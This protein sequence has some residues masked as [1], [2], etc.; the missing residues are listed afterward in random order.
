MRIAK[1]SVFS[2]LN[3]FEI[4]TIVENSFSDKFG[5]LEDEVTTL[6]DYYHSD[7][8]LPVV[9]EWYNG[10][11]FGPYTI[12]NPWSIL[13]CIKHNQITPEPYWVNISSNSLIQ[14]VIQA[15]DNI[16]K[17]EIRQL[18]S[19]Q[20]IQ[21]QIR[22]DFVPTDL[23]NSPIAVFSFLLFSGYLTG[24]KVPD[25]LPAEYSLKIP[26]KEVS[27]V[28]TDIISSWIEQFNSNGTYQKML[29]DLLSGNINSFI[30]YFTAIVS[31]SFSFFDL[32]DDKSENFYHAFI[33]GLFVSLSETYHLRS[34]RESGFGRYDLMLIPKNVD[35]Q[36]NGFVIEFKLVNKRRGETLD[37]AADAA[38]RQIKEKNYSGELITLGVRSIFLI[39]I[40]FEKKNVKV[41]YERQ[42]YNE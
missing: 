19:G 21:K 3:N 29:Q 20:V 4:Y 33:L 9:K 40:A 1:E 10:Y 17:E 31:S 15:S 28:Y 38:I 14:N 34:N 27:Y 16:V 37:S 7:H 2:D 8:T 30:D 36:R 26:N 35:E 11:Q 42:G 5:F 13:N 24:V 23:Q 22:K 39:G 41:L 32:S 6:L 25:S 12:Y 18:L